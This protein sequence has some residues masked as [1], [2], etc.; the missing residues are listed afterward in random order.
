M[1][2][3]VSKII[4]NILHALSQNYANVLKQNPIYANVLVENPIYAN[5]LLENMIYANV[6]KQN[7]MYANVLEWSCVSFSLNKKLSLCAFIY[8]IR[9]FIYYI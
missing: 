4:N 7:L 9:A 6:L 3:T 8:F 2:T 5:V 1:L